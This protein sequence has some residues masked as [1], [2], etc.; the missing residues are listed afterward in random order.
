MQPR[1]QVAQ[2]TPAQQ[3]LA[4]T[5]QTQ[6]GHRQ[7]PVRQR[8]SGRAAGGANRTTPQ[9]PQAPA[10]TCGTPCPGGRPLKELEDGRGLTAGLR[11]GTWREGKGE[12]FE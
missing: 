12:V 3:P 1:S 11:G 2:H 7:S 5:T 10:G 8:N 9:T 6:Q 4:S